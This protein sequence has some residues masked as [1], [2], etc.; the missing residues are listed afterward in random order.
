[1]ARPFVRVDFTGSGRDVRP[2]AL[3]PGV[4]M[5]DRPNVQARTAAK[6]LGR[7]AAEPRW[8]GDRV[9]FFVSDGQGG[10]LEGVACRPVTPQRL[11]GPLKS[12]FEQL[13]HQIDGV[14]TTSRTEQMLQTRLSEPLRRLAADP[15]RDEPGCYLFEYR[16]PQRAWRLVYC[17]GFQRVERQS[18]TPTI[19]GNHECSALFVK[20]PEGDR[21]CPEC[22]YRPLGERIPRKTVALLLV[23]LAAACT[24]GWFWWRSLPSAVLAGR[25]VSAENQRA[26]V[27]GADIRILD[28]DFR[29]TADDHGQFSL[30]R[31]PAGQFTVRVIADGHEPKMATAELIA[32]K[33]TWIEVA[34]TGGAFPRGQV[35]DAA[36]GKPIPEAK[37]TVNGTNAST[38]LTS[39]EGHFRF[40]GVTD[41]KRVRATAAGY[42]E[43]GVDWSGRP[44]SMLLKLT[45]NGVLKGRV[46]QEPDGRPIAGAKIRD[47]RTDREIRADSMGSFRWDGLRAGEAK[48][49]VSA[50]GFAAKQVVVDLPSGP[51]ASTEVRLVGAAGLTGTVLS[52]A[53][54]LPL[55]EATVRIAGQPLEGKADAQ[56]QFRIPGVPGGP[57][58]I[59]VAASGFSPKEIQQELAA[60]SGTAFGEV[61][62]T[63]AGQPGRQGDR[64][65]R[66]AGRSPARW[67]RS[68]ARNSRPTPAPTARTRSRA[69]PAARRR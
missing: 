52:G 50:E 9:E 37:V 4:A 30:P 35:V 58:T 42:R 26:P 65:R 39:A 10:R 53:T 19:C 61:V 2:V 56:G 28:S 29:T 12:E 41:A 23:L 54:G 22:G 8:E 31:L 24:G 33:E 34:L 68:P 1:M 55:P 45:G 6:W 32:H 3:E 64:C 44:D 20:P 17:W 46:L 66:A 62:L 16:D 13:R 36:T 60:D 47:T 25:V 43:E 18:G 14:R 57:A 63:G 7:F 49:N 48:L 11:R 5:L 67:S 51:E 21:R 40:P 59:T 15:M 27:S 69:S 38:L